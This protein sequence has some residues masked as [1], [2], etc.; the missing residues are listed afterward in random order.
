MFQKGIFSWSNVSKTIL[1]GTGYIFFFSKMAWKKIYRKN[2]KNHLRSNDYELC[3][4][5]ARC[6]P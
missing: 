5:V 2:Y 3:T 6:I 4:A 1:K